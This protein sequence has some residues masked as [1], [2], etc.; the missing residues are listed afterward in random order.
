M[1]RDNVLR[2]ALWVSVVFNLGGA[3]VFAFPSSPLGQVAG[4][5]AAVPALY[6]VLVV[7]FVVLFAGAYAW[8]AGQPTIDRPL[9]A[10]A[11]LGKVGFFAIIV[12][13]W[14]LGETPG[15]GVLA[16]TGDLVLAGLFAWWLLG[17]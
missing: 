9:V 16:A 5:P 11:A 12:I 6:R 4:L 17:S 8:L 7:F 13:F 2:R 3:I 14:L 10:F 15:R 1:G